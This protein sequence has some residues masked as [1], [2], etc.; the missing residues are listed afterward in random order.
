MM[1]A[2]TSGAWHLT[3]RQ[4]QVLGLITQGKSNR[5]IAQELGLSENT[6]RVHLV[7]IFK[8]LRVSNRLEAVL[9]RS[10]HLNRR[11]DKLS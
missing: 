1:S 11:V 7:S 4:R 8:E 10:G 3:P 9:A 5:A 6:V 2:E